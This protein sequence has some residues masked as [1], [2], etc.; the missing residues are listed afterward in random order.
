VDEV[1]RTSL[2]DVLVDDLSA[3]PVPGGLDGSALYD[4]ALESIGRPRTRR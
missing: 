2:E 3:V 1:C 4:Q